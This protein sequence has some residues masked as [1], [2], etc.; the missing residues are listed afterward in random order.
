MFRFRDSATKQTIIRYTYSSVVQQH[1]SITKNLQG[2]FFFFQISRLLSFCE[3]DNRTHRRAA[4]GPIFEEYA[5][6]MGAQQTG[7]QL[8]GLFLCQCFMVWSTLGPRS[9]RRKSETEKARETNTLSCLL[10]VRKKYSSTRA[11]QSVKA[12]NYNCKY[13]VFCSCCCCSSLLWR[14][15]RNVHY[16][17]CPCP[18]SNSYYICFKY[19]RLS[20]T[21]YYIM[22]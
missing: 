9:S 21:P 10:L 19:T 4:I 15:Q 17:S 18:V 22:N 12:Y 16:E 11:V 1:S 13:S 3:P 2:R 7:I 6:V 20:A 5:V 14:V 8:F